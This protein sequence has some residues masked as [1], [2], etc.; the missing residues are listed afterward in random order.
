MLLCSVWIVILFTNCRWHSRVL[1][2]LLEKP[3]VVVCLLAALAVSDVGDR[4]ILCVGV[5]LCTKGPVLQ[6]STGPHCW[7]CSFL[8]QLG[9][10]KSEKEWEPRNVLK[11]FTGGCKMCLCTHHRCVP[12]KGEAVH[13]NSKCVC[14]RKVEQCELWISFSFPSCASHHRCDPGVGNEAS[15]NTCGRRWP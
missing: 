15:T 6:G 5:W 12:A 3:L 8:V 7:A 14:F 4:V 2:P 11:L 1:G 13:L 9:N 10:Q